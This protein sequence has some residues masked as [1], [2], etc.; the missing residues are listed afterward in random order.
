MRLR[1][2]LRAG[3]FAVDGAASETEFSGPA[4]A[5]IRVPVTPNR[6]STHVMKSTL[7]S[8]LLL[9]LVAAL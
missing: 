9:P 6:S 3:E 4:G 5:A 2:T 8:A 1:W 7:R